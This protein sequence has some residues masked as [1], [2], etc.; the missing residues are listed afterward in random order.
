MQHAARVGIL[1]LRFY[2]LAIERF[3]RVH[4]ISD[5]KSYFD[6]RARIIDRDLIGGFLMFWI[7]GAEL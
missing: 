3:E 2:L 7:V 4:E 5:I 6:L 1:K